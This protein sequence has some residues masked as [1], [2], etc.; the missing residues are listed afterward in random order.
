MVSDEMPSTV[1][2]RSAWLL[3]AS[4]NRRG[5]TYLNAEVVPRLCADVERIDTRVREIADETT[6]LHAVDADVFALLD[7]LERTWN[8]H[9]I[10]RTNA[11]QALRMMADRVAEL[12]GDRCSVCD[13]DGF[14]YVTV[15]VEAPTG[16][17]IE[18][19]SACPLCEGTRSGPLSRLRRES[20]ALRDALRQVGCVNPRAAATYD[21]CATLGQQLQ[22]VKSCVVCAAL[23]N[24]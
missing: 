11:E 24:G 8:T 18:E 17:E 14:V 7:E 10:A 20:D 13:E 5:A 1:E 9:R 4:C 12:E 23:G 15:G 16:N 21:T 2:E 22:G 19:P 6:G 3:D